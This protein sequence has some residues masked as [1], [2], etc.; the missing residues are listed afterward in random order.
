MLSLIMAKQLQSFPITINE[1]LFIIAIFLIAFG[2]ILSSVILFYLGLIL[3]A[4]LILEKFFHIIFNPTG[5]PKT[6]FE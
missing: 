1:L 5:K 2:G 6:L 4:G 3:L